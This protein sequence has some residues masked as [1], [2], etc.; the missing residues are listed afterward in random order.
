MHELEGYELVRQMADDLVT[1]FEGTASIADA[2]GAPTPSYPA[3]YPG[4]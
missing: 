1:E 3:R 2:F 4:R